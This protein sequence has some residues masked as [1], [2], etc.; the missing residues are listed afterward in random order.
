MHYFNELVDAMDEQWP[1][2]EMHT[3][4]EIDEEDDLRPSDEK[5]VLRNLY[6]VQMEVVEEV[7]D[8]L[9]SRWN[10]R[11]AKVRELPDYAL[12][13]E[14][15]L[16]LRISPRLFGP[17]SLKEKGRWW[18]IA[19]R[20]DDDVRMGRIEAWQ[21]PSGETLVAYWLRDFPDSDVFRDIIEE[22]EQEFQDSPPSA[23]ASVKQDIESEGRSTPWNLIPENRWDRIAVRMWCVGR[24]DV[25]IANNFSVC[26]GRVY[27]RLSE[28]RD[29]YPEAG[30]PLDDERKTVLRGDVK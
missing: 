24:Q 29:Q 28:L 2:A 17:H 16:N 26:P 25:Y 21:V 14:G 5:P 7:L 15:S 6:P 8:T 1:K 4:Y 22:V 11:W 23:N 9:A 3:D 27:N 18:G 30:I 13:G 10:E 19:T 20:D 12:Q